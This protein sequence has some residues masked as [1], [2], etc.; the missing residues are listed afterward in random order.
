MRTDSQVS[1]TGGG[2]GREVSAGTPPAKAPCAA[3]GRRPRGLTP[4]LWQVGMG[5]RCVAFPW[6]RSGL[7]E[8]GLRAGS[9]RPPAAERRG[10]CPPGQ[11]FQN[12][13][14]RKVL[15]PS[16][17]C[18]LNLTL[19]S[20]SPRG[21]QTGTKPPGRKG[22]WSAPSLP[23]GGRTSRQGRACAPPSCCSQGWTA[24][25]LIPEAALTGT[26][27]VTWGRVGLR[28]VWTAPQNVPALSPRPAPRTPLS[29]PDS[30][31]VLGSLR[32]AV[33]PIRVFSSHSPGDPLGRWPP[34]SLSLLHFPAGFHNWIS[35]EHS[36]GLRVPFKLS[37]LLVSFHCFVSRRWFFFR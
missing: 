14:Q 6:A 8:P 20:S 30:P 11:S 25:P 37:E 36:A 22:Q 23:L 24:W 13:P 28:Q 19:T 34:L 21:K 17:G 1:R 33:C 32:N 5:C 27:D 35:T 26:G 15:S 4:G 2:E 16:P 18:S 29:V 9:S 12:V 10:F 7:G 31:G 3:L